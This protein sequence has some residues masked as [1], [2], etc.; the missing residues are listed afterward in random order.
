MIDTVPP[1]LCF[2]GLLDV[3][4]AREIGTWI[5]THKVEIGMKWLALSLIAAAIWIALMRIAGHRR[6]DDI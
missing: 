4:V 5:L 6:D 2:V 3:G 1:P